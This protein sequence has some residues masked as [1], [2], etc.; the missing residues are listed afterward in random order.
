M[1]IFLH[2]DRN[3]LINLSMSVNIGYLSLYFQTNNNK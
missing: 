1:Y 3:N 2:R